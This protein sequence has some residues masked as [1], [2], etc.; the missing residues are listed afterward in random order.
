MA[1]KQNLL[2]L[3]VDSLWADHMSAYGYPRLTTPHIDRFA[4]GGVLFERT[5]SPHIPTTSAYSSMLTGMDCFST[6]VVAL[7]HQ[8]G[9]NPEVQTLPEILKAQGYA[10]TC[11]GFTGNP[12]SR[13]FDQY[14]DF[15]GWG[16]WEQRPSRKAENLN[17]VALPELERLAA[18]EEP[19][20]LFLRHM[21]P[22]SP[23]L[24]PAPFDRM[25]YDGYECDPNNRS[26]D[27]VMSF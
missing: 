2:L 11:V 10:T 9:L 27:T 16:S 23:Y 6:T 20:F 15:S 12:A 24:P 14:L 8:G 1:K 26:M 7:R 4:Q 21:D 5:Y 3:G 17:D 25:F 18:G 13:G 22:H 19:F